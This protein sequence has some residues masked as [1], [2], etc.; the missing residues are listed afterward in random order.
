MD[1]N[2]IGKLIESE[3]KE[4]KSTQSQLATKIFVSEKLFQSGKLA[5]G[6]LMQFTT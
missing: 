1:Y 3:I 5:K 6:F 4:K 2:K